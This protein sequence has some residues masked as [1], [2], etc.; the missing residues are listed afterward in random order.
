[1]SNYQFA[2]HKINCFC[3]LNIFPVIQYTFISVGSRSD[4]EL[5]NIGYAP[6]RCKLE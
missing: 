1:M 3:C 2:G 6:S 5:H 4:S